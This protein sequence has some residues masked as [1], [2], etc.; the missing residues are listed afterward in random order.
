MKSE[1][2]AWG[3]E[4][5]RKKLRRELNWQMN[6]KLTVKFY[7]KLINAR[8]EIKQLLNLIIQ[9]E[10]FFEIPIVELLFYLDARVNNL[11]STSIN[12][13]RELL[14]YSVIS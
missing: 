6:P 10:I 8:R 7:K 3:G 1:F 2:Q 4:T 13:T 5:G 14:K 11:L 9:K 12:K